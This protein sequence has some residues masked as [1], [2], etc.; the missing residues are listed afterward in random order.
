MAD[1]QISQLTENSSPSTSDLF[2]CQQSTS[3]KKILLS[4]IR[5]FIQDFT[6]ASTVSTPNN[7]DYIHLNTSSGTNRKI[8]ASNLKNYCSSGSSSS[9][10]FYATYGT[11]TLAQVITAFNNGQ[12]VFLK[13]GVSVIPL[14]QTDLSTYCEFYNAKSGA[15]YTVDSNGWSSQ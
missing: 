5:T 8:S 4:T 3:A 12:A 7:T 1:K 2:V 15:I 13:A 10:T 14:S 6:N 9:G 11:T